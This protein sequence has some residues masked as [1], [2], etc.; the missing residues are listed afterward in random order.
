MW[1]HIADVP[2]T[3]ALV[4]LAARFAVFFCSC[5]LNQR[6]QLPQPNKSQTNPHRHLKQTGDVNKQKSCFVRPEQ[7]HDTHTHTQNEFMGTLGQDS[8]CSVFGESP[9]VRKSSAA[10]WRWSFTRRNPTL[11]GRDAWAGWWHPCMSQEMD[12]VDWVSVSPTVNTTEISHVEASDV[13]S[14]FC[15]AEIL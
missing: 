11:A 14:L 8:F 15:A 13:C 9:R 2:V 4:V 1:V 6:K 3:H 12:S 5:S 10:G 7:T